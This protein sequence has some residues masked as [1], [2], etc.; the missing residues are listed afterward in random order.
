[1]NTSIVLVGNLTADPELRYT[2]TGTAVVRFTVAVNH[3]Y[4]DKT[5]Q[6]WKDGDP[7]FY[8]VDAWRL[9]A[10]NCA[11]TLS[12]GHRVVIAGRLSQRRYE[13]KDGSKRV[14]WTVTADAV[15]ADL[16]YA[17]AAI[18]KVTRGGTAPDDPWANA[19]PVRPDQPAPH[20]S[21]E[22]PF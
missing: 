15:G 22:V 1:M 8:D 4:Q 5:T 6:E 7:D 3:R 21:D 10:E 20:A 11:E 19:S 18:R 17:T 12:K 2:P 9:L 16:T 13:A 14:A